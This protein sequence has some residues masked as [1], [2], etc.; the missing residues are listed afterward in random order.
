MRGRKEG[1]AGA[2]RAKTQE[3]A[4]ALRH[5]MVK[6]AFS[7]STGAEAAGAAAAGAGAA[8]AGA[9]AMVAPRSAET[10][11]AE[12]AVAAGV[13]CARSSWALFSRCS[14]DISFQS[15]RARLIMN[16]INASPP[17]AACHSF[18]HV[19]RLS[20][21]KAFLRKLSDVTFAEAALAEAALAEAALAEAALAE[22]ALAEA[23]ATIGGSRCA[24]ATTG[25]VAG[26]SAEAAVWGVS[27]CV[28]AELAAGGSAE[29]AVWGPCCPAITLRAFSLRCSS[30][31]ASH[32]SRD[33]RCK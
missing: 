33:R 10:G 31:I 4:A 8:A 19:A 24:T 16:V 25:P 32:I 30:D 6:A 29:A 20:F 23:A 26:G 17:L 21:T 13:V 12:A 11:G 27:A 22:A 28:L 1:F 15:C 9:A 7:V 18:F 2:A 3:T 5:C 14:M